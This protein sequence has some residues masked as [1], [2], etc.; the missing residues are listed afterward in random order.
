MLSPVNQA[1]S[2]DAR[3]TTAGAMSSGIPT[4]P[5]GVLATASL[6]GRTRKEICRGGTLGL[7]QARCYRV[8]LI[9]LGPSSFERT[10]VTESI[11]LFV[12]E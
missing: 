7:G 11:A 8:H 2:S 1:E 3:K 12:A 10:R 9:F 5:S 6:P 4:R